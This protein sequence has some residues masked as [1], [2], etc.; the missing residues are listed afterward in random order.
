MKPSEVVM[1]TIKPI[2]VNVSDHD[3]R[4]ASW[5]KAER[6]VVERLKK[7]ILSHVQRNQRLLRR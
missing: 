7:R 6:K 3:E 2:V 1:G 4:L 5:R